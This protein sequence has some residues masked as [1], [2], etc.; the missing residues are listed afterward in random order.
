MYAAV[1]ESSFSES[2][3]VSGDPGYILIDRV[4]LDTTS[5]VWQTPWRVRV[6]AYV[7]DLGAEL[8]SLAYAEGETDARAIADALLIIH[9]RDK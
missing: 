8:V 6:Y 9:L 5:T 3:Y 1:S 2:C 7:D 4:P